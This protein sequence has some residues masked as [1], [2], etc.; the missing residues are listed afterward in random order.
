MSWLDQIGGV[1]E[2]YTGE[3]AT[4]PDTEEHFNQIAQ[5][6]PQAA[7]SEG[8]AQAFR[9]DQTPPFQEMLSQLFG[10]AAPHQR[11]GLLN[12]LISAVG[13]ALV[14]QV[15]G[16]KGLSGLAGLLSGGQSQVSPEQATNVPPDAVGEIAARA[17]E[18]N[19]NII[20][21]VSRY[22]SGHPE[23]LKQLGHSGISNILMGMAQKYL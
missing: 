2:Q 8:V 23:L 10:G 18:Q 12:L 22:V 13:P 17:V 6:A 3:G 1:L 4:P 16:G 11:A 5:A 20:D 19:P 21:Q 9:S 14:S 15:L 7:L